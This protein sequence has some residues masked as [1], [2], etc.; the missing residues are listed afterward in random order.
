[1]VEQ[2]VQEF[3]KEQ[4]FTVRGYPQAQIEILDS[5]PKDGLPQPLDKN[6]V[7]MGFHFDEGGVQAE[8]G[9]DLKRRTYVLEVFVFGLSSIWGGN[10]ASTIRDAADVDG[11]IPLLDLSAAGSP[12]IDKLVVITAHARR[13]PINNPQPWEE[14]VWTVTIQVEDEYWASL[15]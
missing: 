10:L 8:L 12:E 4:L 14:F 3:L 15:V 6:Y 11:V 2:S 5:F 1:M 7:A 9:S 13:E